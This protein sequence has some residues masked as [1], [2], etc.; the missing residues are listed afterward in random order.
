MRNAAIQYKGY[1]LKSKT[2]FLWA[3]RFE[4]EGYAWEYEPTRF[5]ADGITPGKQFYTP[6]FSV[7]VRTLFIEIK[8]WGATN[9]ENNF[10]LCPLPL[11]I[12]FGTPDRHYVRVKPTGAAQL[13]RGHFRHWTL[14]YQKVAA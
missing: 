2:E 14:A 7:D 9:L 13:D 3:R 6:D 1:S 11:L 4:V 8:I 10:Y 12:I 5:R